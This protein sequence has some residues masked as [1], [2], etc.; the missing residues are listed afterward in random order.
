M[1]IVH[2]V[3]SVSERTQGYLHTLDMIF[4]STE[5]RSAQLPG[6][7]IPLKRRCNRRRRVSVR[8]LHCGGELDAG[9]R[10]MHT[11]RT[12]VF[13]RHRVSAPSLS[14]NDTKNDHLRANALEARSIP[15]IF[16]ESVLA[17]LTVSFDQT[18]PIATTTLLPLA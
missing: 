2:T 4:I 16:S 5:A 6:L 9:P 15:I 8:E 3:H 13:L 7:L 17:R 18:W 14:R 11:T 12:S 1:V 10:R